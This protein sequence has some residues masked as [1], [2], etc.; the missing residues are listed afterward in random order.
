MDEDR[1]FAHFIDVRAEFRCALD[2]CAEKIDPDRL[3]VGADQVEH[4][5]S[6]IGVAG[7]GEAIKLVLGHW[8]SDLDAFS[9]KGSSAYRSW[10]ALHS[11]RQPA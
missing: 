5:R 2:H 6:A 9:V 1:R 11:G 10:T 4:E 7:L 3:P 8:I